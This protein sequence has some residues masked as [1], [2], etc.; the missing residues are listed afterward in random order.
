VDTLPPTTGPLTATPVD[1]LID[2]LCNEFEDAW[3]ANQAQPIE[4]FL[5]R[6]EPANRKVLLRELVA[7]E[8][9]YRHNADEPA[10]I[11]EYKARFPD[12]TI[13]MSDGP[14]TVDPAS[15]IQV[16]GISVGL[17]LQIDN[18]TLLEEIARGGMGIVYRARDTA[19]DREVAVKVLQGRFRADSE[20]SRRF[21]E[22]A[23]ITGQ[24]QHPSI[25]AIHQVGKLPDGRP[26]LA[27]KLIRGSTLADMLDNDPKVGKRGLAKSAMAL[28]ETDIAP[29]DRGRFIPIFEQIC[30]AVGYAHAHKVIHRDLKPANVMVGAFG[31]V[32]VMDWGL[33]KVVGEK[34]NRPN[35]VNFTEETTRI[36]KIRS[37]RDPD[38]RTSAGSIFGTLAFMSPEQAAGEVEKLGPRSDVFSLGAILCVI[39][40]G[41]PPY[42]GRTAEEVHLLAVHGKLGW[43]FA[44]MESCGARRELIALAKHCLAFDPGDRPAHAGIVAAAVAEMRA[45]T[46]ARARHVE[47]EHARGEEQL[48]RKRA[49]RNL[50]ISVFGLAFLIAVGT[51]LY[52]ENRRKEAVELAQRDVEAAR[53]EAADIRNKVEPIRLAELRAR[54]RLA[55]VEYGRA[56][57]L[58]HE[59]WRGNNVTAASRL[60]DS[61]P[62]EVR[63]WEPPYTYRPLEL[64]GWEWDYVHRLCQSN[65]RT[66]KEQDRARLESLSLNGH[67]GPVVSAAWSPDGKKVVTVGADKTPIIWDATTGARIQ[68]LNG[69]TSSVTSG[70]FSRDGSLIV[71]SS[72]D[73]T[74]I[75][76]DS[77]SGKAIQTLRGHTSVVTS[78]SWNPDG[79][80]VA[81]ASLDGTIKVWDA[82]TG[83]EIRNPSKPQSGRVNPLYSVA[84]SP[85]GTQFVSGSEDGS[86]NIWSLESKY[87]HRTLHGPRPVRSIAWNR[88]GSRILTVGDMTAT[89]WDARLPLQIMTLK[90]HIQPVESAQWSPD[91]S[92][93][94][95]ASADRTAKVWH[96]ESGVELLILKDHNGIVR[97]AS[98]SPDGSRIVT[99]SAD[100]TARIWDSRPI[101][102][103]SFP[104]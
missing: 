20:I 85:K 29:D 57:G 47:L 73:T 32:Q 103:E 92:R 28:T 96:A 56:M 7:I 80:K 5:D 1:I 52:G 82:M 27:M 59:L 98:F 41:H 8:M 69:H 24:L 45:A 84:W 67:S 87:D 94:V 6:V 78:A 34:A 16:D 71:T 99:V 77:S 89:V 76:W 72:D 86:I 21:I 68:P 2:R 13:S 15:E 38:S 81:T 62:S 19:L 33:A 36:T 14:S 30:H 49:Q 79:T 97:S 11:D 42:M 54:E 40:T 104:K 51:V 44:K 10:L 61:T 58:A 31:E 90:G 75:I 101:N 74:A 4:R 39:L 100:G 25:P 17:P 102:R 37:G 23:R 12:L 9:A 88:D 70:S 26:Y 63:G 83:L 46:Q 3:K 93:I 91:Q 64:R 66:L 35:L 55:V 18:F 60:L 43:A 50:T 65:N 95:T 53:K 22:E 48:K